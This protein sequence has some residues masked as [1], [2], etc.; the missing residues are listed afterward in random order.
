MCSHLARFA[1]RCT[2]FV[3]LTLGMCL[4]GCA[5]ATAP[6]PPSSAYSLVGDYVLTWGFLMA[7]EGTFT[8]PSALPDF[9][10]VHGTINCPG[11]LDVTQQTSSGISGTFRAMSGASDCFGQQGDFCALAGVASFCRS[12]SGSWSG[13]FFPALL[14]GTMGSDLSFSTSSGASPVEAL[15]GCRVVA[16]RA[17]GT[18]LASFRLPDSTIST[19]LLSGSV[20]TATIDCPAST[21][22]GR[23]DVSVLFHGGRTVQP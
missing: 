6:P 9:T 7:D 16:T 1:R 20:A 13:T 5:S 3:V 22:F 2:G 14:P 18:G 19:L 10:K 8:T 11:E 12:I 23:V 21:G 4:A 17:P 15:T